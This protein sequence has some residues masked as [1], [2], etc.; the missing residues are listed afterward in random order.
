MMMM[1]YMKWVALQLGG[2]AHWCCDVYLGN[3][4][5]H[6][7]LM[8]EAC[9]LR[10]LNKASVGV[11]VKYDCWAG[12]WG[13]VH[14]C[15]SCCHYAGGTIV[16]PA[17]MGST[18]CSIRRYSHAAVCT[19]WESSSTCAPGSILAG[20][21]LINDGTFFFN[22][23]ELTDPFTPDSGGCSCATGNGSQYPLPH[24]EGVGTIL[25]NLMGVSESHGSS[26]AFAQNNVVVFTKKKKNGQSS[27]SCCC[28]LS[29][30]RCRSDKN[31]MLWE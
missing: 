25:V 27:P 24:L 29:F 26:L 20:A 8:Q 6:L 17:P 12:T 1:V 19:W 3:D 18:S 21:L 5:R 7:T 11:G 22:F 23:I 9:L 28:R 4:A 13:Q 16:E 31:F 15:P 10:I 30:L 14:W 2:N